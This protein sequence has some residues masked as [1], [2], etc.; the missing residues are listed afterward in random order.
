ML[1]FKQLRKATENLYIWEKEN[2]TGI[3]IFYTTQKEISAQ[4]L[5]LTNKIQFAKTLPGT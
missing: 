1:D 2:T 5:R 4:V 3:I